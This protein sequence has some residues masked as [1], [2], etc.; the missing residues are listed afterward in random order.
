MDQIFAVRQLPMQNIFSKSK[1]VYWGLMNLE[2]KYER[3]DREELWSA[4]SLGKWK[5]LRK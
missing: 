2:K 4:L 1:D 3:T 5:I